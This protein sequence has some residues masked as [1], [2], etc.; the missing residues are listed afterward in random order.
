MS[1]AVFRVDRAL[2]QVPTPEGKRFATIFQHGSLLMEI[3]APRGTDPQQPHSRDEG[4][5]VIKGEG[6]F[7]IDGR[8]ERFGPG[9]FIFAAAGIPHR[10]EEFSDD[11]AVWVIFY[12]PEGGED[13][14]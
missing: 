4:Y 13:D 6:W 14:D 11:L 8:R 7:W 2:S 3:Y 10:F 1:Q 5:V 12:G 9:D